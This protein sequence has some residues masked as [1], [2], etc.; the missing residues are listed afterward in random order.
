MVRVESSHQSASVLVE[1]KYTCAVVAY[2]LTGGLTY[3]LLVRN[4]AVFDYQ[5]WGPIALYQC[6]IAS[7]HGRVCTVGDG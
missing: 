6:F 2:A 7:L 3:T 1:P 4:A 5:V